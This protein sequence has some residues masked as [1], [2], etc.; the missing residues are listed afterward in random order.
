MQTM[1]SGGVGAESLGS[2]YDYVALGHI[3]CPQW[4]RGERKRARY[5]GSPRAIHFD[6]AYPHGVDVVTVEAGR[7]P[8]ASGTVSGKWSP[9]IR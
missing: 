1:R 6:E 5:C 4:I 2:A 8:F 3:H 9:P 7:E